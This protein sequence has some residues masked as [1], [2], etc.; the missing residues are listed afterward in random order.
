LDIKSRL[1][2][3][4][5]EVDD[6]ALIIGVSKKQPIEKIVEAY[7]AGLRD[8][9]ENYA[10]EMIEK[11]KQL[12]DLSEIRWHFIG[13]LQKNKVNQIFPY[14]FSLHT[15]DSL[16]LA[17]KLNRCCEESGRRLD[18]YLQINIDG[19][20][21]KSGI[22]PEKIFEFLTFLKKYEQLNLLGLMCIP[23]PD[24]DPKIAFDALRELEQKC[25]PIT[26]GKLSMGMS[27][28]YM[29]AVKCGSTAIRIGT[30]LFGPRELN[31]P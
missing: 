25:R 12:S 10:Q 24:K 14:L 6:R 2:T 15:L 16:K 13:H 11:A 30:T 26:K 18:V 31:S 9:G 27:S 4:E 28:D 1:E 29:I 3:I 8:F 5:T 19:E 22:S 21:S 20:D 17:E 7:H 23:S